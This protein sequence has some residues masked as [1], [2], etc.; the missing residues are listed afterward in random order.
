[1]LGTL[2]Q[3]ERD[4]LRNAAIFISGLPPLEMLGK[5]MQLLASD[6]EIAEYIRSCFKWA[7]ISLDAFYGDASDPLSD[8]GLDET[9]QKIVQDR[10]NTYL[11][12]SAL[13]FQ[14]EKFL[15]QEAKAEGIEYPF[16]KRSD[17]LKMVALEDC[18]HEIE[19]SLQTHWDSYSEAQRNERLR[20]SQKYLNGDMSEDRFKLIKERWAKEDAK[21]HRDDISLALK[22]LYWKPFCLYVF[23]KHRKKLPAFNALV[24]TLGVPEGKHGKFTIVNGRSQATPGRGPG[25]AK[26]RK[27]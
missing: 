23:E 13:I 26:R 9:M 12:F 1:M 22:T 15:K 2:P 20:D 21:L 14:G 19:L 3:S 5:M 27:F 17:L 16:K 18:F 10:S 8:S 11:I 7:G 4:E 6:P 25:R 24:A